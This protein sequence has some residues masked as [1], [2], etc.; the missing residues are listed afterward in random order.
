MQQHTWR[1]G[2]NIPPTRSY[3]H[4]SK[5]DEIREQPTSN[6]L[7]SKQ[8]YCRSVTRSSADN[9]ANACASS[10]SSPCVVTGTATPIHRHPCSETGVSKARPPTTMSSTSSGP[11]LPTLSTNIRSATAEVAHPPDD[12]SLQLTLYM[13]SCRD[14]VRCD[15]CA[16]VALYERPTVP[17]AWRSTTP[18]LNA[19]SSSPTSTPTDTQPPPKCCACRWK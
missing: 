3:R 17:Y 12:V 5:V 9:E 16:V 7:Q 8:L 2:P 11:S 4:N 1:P 15:A 18:S 6:T 13:A 19:T 14:P 10:S